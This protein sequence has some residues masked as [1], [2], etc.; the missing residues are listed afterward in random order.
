MPLA[1]R[2]GSWEKEGLSVPMAQGNCLEK[3]RKK[4]WQLEQKFEQKMWKKIK[5]LFKQCKIGKLILIQWKSFKF[6]KMKN[7]QNK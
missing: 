6:H 2:K 7:R 5:K 3:F 1:P 4:T